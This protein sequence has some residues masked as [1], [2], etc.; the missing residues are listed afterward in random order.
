M[1]TEPK[2]NITAV[3]ALVIALIVAFIAWIIWVTYLSPKARLLQKIPGEPALPLL[4]HTHILPTGANDFYN[5]V[6][7]LCEKYQDGGITRLQLGPIYNMIILFKA[8]LVEPILNSNNH[9]TK[10]HDYDVLH[11]WLGTGLLTSTGTKWKS[12]RR[13]LTPSFHFQILKDFLL[14]F[15]EQVAVMLDKL[16]TN[17]EVVNGKPFDIFPAITNC[18]LDIICET[19][20]GS[21]PNAQNNENSEYVDAVF[22]ISELVHI[23]QKQPWLW[24]NLVY[25]NITPGKRFAK[26]LKTLHNF[27][28]KV[29]NDRR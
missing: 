12:R 8:P 21:H 4:G 10:A 24:P 28:N 14:V 7:E 20:M 19:A 27:T 9:I 17:K 11:P 23:R 15:N 25:N 1:G 2:I 16:K 13:L 3:A 5:K 29:I 18:A 26:C 22:E 6:T